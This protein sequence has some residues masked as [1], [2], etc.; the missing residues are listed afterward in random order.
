MLESNVLVISLFNNVK[1]IDPRWTLGKD[2]VYSQTLQTLEEKTKHDFQANGMKSLQAHQKK[3]RH[4]SATIERWRLALSIVARLR[5]FELEAC[6]SCPY[7]W[8][9]CR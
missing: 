4:D 2:G 8:R 9:S 6:N 5:G 3:L 7:V 1:P